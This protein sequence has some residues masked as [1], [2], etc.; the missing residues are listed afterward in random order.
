LKGSFKP[1]KTVLPLLLAIVVGLGLVAVPAL[2]ASSRPSNTP[3]STNTTG[4]G[5]TSRGTN[6]G[7]TGLVAG[8]ASPP[9]Q[10]NTSNQTN[11]S[12]LGTLTPLVIITVALILSLG[13]N[14]LARSRVNK[15]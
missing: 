10:S 15:D 7:F 6:P 11:Q 12:L 3:A 14:R 8:P 4:P 1:G 2:V 5:T 13:V 9:S